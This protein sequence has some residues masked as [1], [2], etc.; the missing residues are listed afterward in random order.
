ML[1]KSCYFEKQLIASRQ[2][3]PSIVIY[4]NMSSV[5]LL[6]VD[7]LCF[8]IM[9]V[10]PCVNNLLTLTSDLI[11]AKKYTKIEEYDRFSETNPGGNPRRIASQERVRPE[12]QSR[13]QT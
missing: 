7:C 5:F 6:F 12:Y 11:I 10:L 13:S 2:K 9:E 8:S 1:N 3:K 4:G